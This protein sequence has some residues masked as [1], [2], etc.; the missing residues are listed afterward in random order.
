M[1]AYLIGGQLELLACIQPARSNGPAA[2]HT[3]TA[4]SPPASHRPEVWKARAN[5]VTAEE[6]A[7][8]AAAHCYDEAE[9]QRLEA[10]AKYLASL[11][12]VCAWLVGV[13]RGRGAS[14][15]V[16]R[17]LRPVKTFAAV[18]RGPATPGSQGCILALHQLSCNFTCLPACPRREAKFQR[19]QEQRRRE[20]EARERQ[21]QA[22]ERERQRQAAAAAAAAERERER[23]RQAAERERQRQAA[24]QERQ[25]QAAAEAE[26]R[27]QQGMSREELW[28]VGLLGAL[29]E[30]PVCG[31]ALPARRRHLLGWALWCIGC[32]GRQ[33]VRAERHT[34]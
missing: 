23:Q 21:R 27:R 4:L 16:S 18:V 1:A 15:A 19:E 30:P 28:E 12:Q 5:D 3:H 13:P 26:R 31:D 7:D 2:N 33:A 25:R 29:L 11:R 34:G 24:E 9:R 6:Q 22:A 14:H 32:M 17:A 10:A 20:A 8:I